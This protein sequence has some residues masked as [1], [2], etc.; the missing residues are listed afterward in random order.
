MAVDISRLPA[1]LVMSFGMYGNFLP[2]HLYTEVPSW[3]SFCLPFKVLLFLSDVSHVSFL[4]VF[5]DSY[6]K[7]NIYSFPR[8]SKIITHL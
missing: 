6:R 8:D 7:N 5:S 1:S 3:L 2:C 4:G